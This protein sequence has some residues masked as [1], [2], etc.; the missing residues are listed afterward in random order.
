MEAELQ[1]ALF[2]YKCGSGGGEVPDP[3]TFKGAQSSTH[4]RRLID[5]LGRSS[6]AAGI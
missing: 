3:A 4:G 2:L 5:L 6:A 1:V